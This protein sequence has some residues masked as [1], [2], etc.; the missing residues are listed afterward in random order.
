MKITLE[1]DDAI[2]PSVQQYLRTQ[3]EVKNDTVTKAQT[4]TDLFEGP[5][6]F[7]QTKVSELM[8]QIVQ[9]YPTPEIRQRMAAA[10]VINDEIKKMAGAQRVTS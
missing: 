1:I 9:Q 10:Q 8:H 2:I 6:H 3:V 5:E 4:M 7:L